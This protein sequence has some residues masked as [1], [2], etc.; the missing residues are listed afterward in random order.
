MAEAS[1]DMWGI[2]IT[3]DTSRK[4]WNRRVL[5]TNVAHRKSHQAMHKL[6]TTALSDHI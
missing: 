1:N 3:T 5:A 6:L 2:Y 4:N